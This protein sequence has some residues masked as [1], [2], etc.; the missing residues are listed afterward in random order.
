[1]SSAYF[2]KI[3][4][5]MKC[6]TGKNQI[7]NVGKKHL[8]G[9]HFHCR[10]TGS[11]FQGNVS[12]L[13]QKSWENITLFTWA[14]AHKA[15]LESQWSQQI[16]FL[17]ITP[18]NCFLTRECQLKLVRLGFLCIF[19]LQL[20]S[21]ISSIAVNDL[22]SDVKEREQRLLPHTSV[23]LLPPFL[24]S[25]TFWIQI[26]TDDL[27]ISEFTRVDFQNSKRTLSVDMWFDANNN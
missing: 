18:A 23:R 8:L 14:H 26:R 3:P 11:I 16:S 17:K 12:S 15:F 1:M 22:D 20:D 5:S 24:F 6:C 10:C 9:L 27:F 4:L 13:E 19:L 25:L 2:W 21:R 7:R